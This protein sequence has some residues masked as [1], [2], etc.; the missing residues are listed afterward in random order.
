METK[1]KNCDHNEFMLVGKDVLCI[2]CGNKLEF[3]L[4][5]LV[6]WKSLTK[7]EE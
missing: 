4:K 7:K 2:R 1:C 6:G 5:R 3:N